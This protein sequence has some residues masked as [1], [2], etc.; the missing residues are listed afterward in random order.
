MENF[1]I[2]IEPVRLILYQIEAFFPR[3]LVAVI[4]VIGGWMLVKVARFAATK[5]LRASTSMS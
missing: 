2:H 5:T 4:V 1:G 3:L